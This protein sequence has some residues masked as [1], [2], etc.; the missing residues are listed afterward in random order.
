MLETPPP[1]QLSQ[2]ISQSIAPAFVL[3][4]VA[5]FIS[6]L[7][8]RLNRIIDRC[9]LVDGHDQN[10]G[11]PDLVGVVDI[12]R[13]NARAELINR[14][15]LWAVGSALSTLLLMIVAFI[16][17]FFELPHERGVGFLFLVALVLFGASL[18]YFGREIRI[19]IKD[20]N[21]FD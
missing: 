1:S 8:T 21:N 4:A 11:S 6:V 18:T 5:S 16:S 9:R 20:P 2:V 15:I 19:V 3:G 13:L 17:A 7:V 12:S 14:A 10:R